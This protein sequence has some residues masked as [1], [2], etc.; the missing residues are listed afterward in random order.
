M[1]PSC[2]SGTGGGC[3]P[4]AGGEG[5]GS[6]ATTLLL[7][8][9]FEPGDPR[10]YFTVYST[11][12][13]YGGTPYNREFDEA[14]KSWK[15]E[16]WSRTGHTPSKMN[17]PWDPNRFPN[18]RSTNNVR[19]IRY[20]DVLLMLAEAKL[21]GNNDLAG[22]AGLINQVRARARDSYKY[23]YGSESPDAELYA[24]MGADAPA[25]LLP[26]VTPSS[27]EQMLTALMHERRVEFGEEPWPTRYDDLV[28]WH[29]AGFIDLKSWNFG[30][31]VPANSWSEKNLLRP[32]P[33]AELDQ[34]PNLTQNDGY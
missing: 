12:E 17:R 16:L 32:I 13:D 21:L 11:D 4:K 7:V 26:D 31:T 14:T 29:R 34:N 19:V 33:Q 2:F 1:S 5:Y 24:A 28:R 18:N 22:A 3:A 15:F 25:N 23:A 9:E 27:K 6:V 8:D 30:E 20:D 10:E